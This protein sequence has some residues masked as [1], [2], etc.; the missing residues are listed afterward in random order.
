MYCLNV[1]F[2]FRY[3]TELMKGNFHYIIFHYL[4][5]KRTGGFD[6]LVCIPRA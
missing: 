2:F 6:H 4:I 5:F 1:S 3:P